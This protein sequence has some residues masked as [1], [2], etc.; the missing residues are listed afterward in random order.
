MHS[1]YAAQRSGPCA[2]GVEA[3]AAGGTRAALHLHPL[4]PDVEA[5]H[6]HLG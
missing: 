3:H 2:G 6:L 4:P 5:R 1:L